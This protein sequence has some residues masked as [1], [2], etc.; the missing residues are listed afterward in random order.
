MWISLLCNNSTPS[1]KKNDGVSSRKLAAMKTK[2][3][4]EKDDA[5]D[6]EEYS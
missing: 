2:E 4:E 6:D 3:E 5:E 1:V